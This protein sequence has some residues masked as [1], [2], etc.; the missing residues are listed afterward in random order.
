M[1]Y[2]HSEETLE[3]PEN[4]T[5]ANSRPGV[6]R[7]RVEEITRRDSRST[8]IIGKPTVGDSKGDATGFCRDTG[9]DS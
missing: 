5:Y 4:G 2:I 7:E 3:V 8:T 9:C 6:E 1:R